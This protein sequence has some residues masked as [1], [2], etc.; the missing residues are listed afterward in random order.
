MAEFKLDRF[1]YNWK[2]EW[3]ENTPYLKDDIV[4]Y[5]GKTYACV[6]SHT[7]DADFFTTYGVTP[8]VS[9]ITV[10]NDT[11]LVDGLVQPT[12]D[13]RIGEIYKFDLSDPSLAATTF[14]FS[15]RADGPVNDGVEFTTGVTVAGAPGLTDSHLKISIQENTPNLFYYNSVT[16][17]YGNAATIT[18]SFWRLI[19]DGTSWKKNWTASTYYTTG[20][21][22]KF[23][24]YI[25][26]CTRTHTSV[27]IT[28]LGPI[29]DIEK[30]K[31][32]ATTYNWLNLWT[33]N[34][35]Y[36]LG[37]VIKYNGIVYI[38]TQKHRS[39]NSISDGLEFDQGKWAIVSKSDDWKTDWQPDI[40]Y[41]PDDVVR[42]GA[43]SYR[44][45]AGHTSSE[46]IDGG[47]ENDLANWEVVVS[48]IEYK[49]DWQADNR[50]KLNDIVKW[51]YSLWIC[52]TPHTSQSSLRTDES[53]WAVWLPGLGYEELWSV[54]IEYRKGDIVLY[55]G[56]SYTALQNSFNSP[57]SVNGILQDTGEWELLKQGYKHRGEWNDS[58]QFKTGD[59]VRNDGILY[60]A[61]AD[62]VSEFPDLENSWQILVTGNYWKQ[63]WNDNTVYYI[64]DV[65]TYASTAYVCILRHTST[66]SESRPDLDIL[67]PDQNYWTLLIQ[68]TET[69][70]LTTRGDI[71]IHD[72]I[73]TTRLAIGESGELLKVQDTEVPFWQN[74]EE[75]ADVYYVSASTG[76]DNPNYGSTL[77]APY[78]T[79]RYACQQVASNTPLAGIN[80]F[81]YDIS[82]AFDEYVLSRAL[83]IMAAGNALT[84]AASFESFLRS[85]N[86]RSGDPYFDITANGGI[87]PVTN[88]A[89]AAFNYF[90]G[91]SENDTEENLRIRDIINYLYVNAGT[92][93]TAV[94]LSSNNVQMPV[95]F[96]QRNATI[97][98]KTGIYSETLPISIPRNTTLVG[99]ELRSTTVQPAAGFETSNM[100]YVNNGSGIRNMTLTGLSGQLS[101]SSNSF[102]TRRPTA[103]A[104]VSLD[105]GQGASD[106]SVWITNKSPYIQNVT[107][108]GTGCIGLKVDGALHNGGNKSATA[109]DFTQILSDGIGYWVAN[110]GRSE[111]VSVFTYYN[112][113]GYLATEGGK[114]RAT[115]G[116]NSYGTYGVAAEGVNPAETPITGQM[117]NRSQ[118]ALIHTVNTDGSNIL[119]LGYTNAG[120]NYTTA[121][122]NV[123]GSNNNFDGR[124]SEF[125]DEA[126]Y[127][128]R[129]IDPADS[130]TPGGLN[131]QYLLNNAQ[132]GNTV[133]I[134][135][136]A[137]DSFGTS[138]AYTGMRLFIESGA[139]AGQYGYITSYDPTSKLATISREVDDAAGWEHIYPGYPIAAELD[140]TTRYSIEPRSIVEQPTF[141]NT[142]VSIGVDV[143]SMAFGAGKWV[144]IENSSQTTNYSVNGNTWSTGSLG[145]AGAW[146]NIVFANNV[147][148]VTSQADTTALL[149]SVNGLTWTGRTFNSAGVNYKAAYGNNIWIAV[150][151][152]STSGSNTQISVNDGIVWTDG[153]AVPFGARALD[154][155]Y[156]NGKFVIVEPS[157]TNAA[158]T[159]DGNSWNSIA[160]PLN[161]AWT[162]IKYGNGR[163]VLIGTGGDTLYSFDAITWYT[164]V[165][166]DQS[167][168][169]LGYGQGLFLAISSTSPAVA[170]SRDGQTWSII[171]NDSTVKE[172]NSTDNWTN[173]VFGN[174]NN[175]GAWMFTQLDS[176]DAEKVLTGAQAFVRTK[177]GTSR[178]Q[179]FVVY[180]P[181]SGYKTTPSFSIIDPNATIGALCDL[182]I[183]N[184]VLSQPE[185]RNRGSGYTRAV[186]TVAGDGFSDNYQI[187]NI[188]V[189]K[190]LTRRPDAG[191][192]LDILGI[193]ST[194]F[195]ITK[196][197]SITG[198]QPN[199]TASIR[200][201]PRIS[202]QESPNHEAGVIIRQE[203]SQ[204]RITGH[205]F[206][207]IGTGN[208]NSTKYPE[209]YLEGTESDNERQPFNEV[210]EA[211]GGRVFYTST[212]QEGNFR[213]GELFTVEQSTGIVS[214]NADFFDLGGLD[215]LSLGG[216]QVGGSAVVIREFSKESTFTANS[217]NIVPTQAAIIKFLE[218]RISG[219]GA[220]AITNVLVAAQVRINQN[221]IST[222]S[223]LPIT[224][225]QKMYLVKG[226]DGHYLASMIYGAS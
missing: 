5:R 226:A 70:V 54:G 91:A 200:I 115:N 177:V 217:N 48:G 197:E 109:N 181:G 170:H 167:W 212:D 11:F 173:I 33:I 146:N 46:Y 138:E 96:Q 131:Y 196:V 140:S 134:L 180:D 111:L 40:R 108:F 185:I 58:T 12:L 74:F 85:T 8:R 7:S 36:D 220:N 88:D 154:I 128:A 184:G 216:I 15:N 159:T 23:K 17:G 75:I 21:I 10:E 215:E 126:I 147:F 218:S 157:S 191:D 172:L 29:N 105:P 101:T 161:R 25:Y 27:V 89:T 3:V 107:T 119:A 145:A 213:V 186:G 168:T 102:G 67:Q 144:A 202:N 34:T 52:V 41:R 160:L 61:T 63:E 43:I 222:T 72:D 198:T 51:R 110:G 124:Y 116:N 47:F 121:T 208:F 162:A 68:G 193:D 163:F 176:R 113:I 73:S 141:V 211:G 210:F 16:P 125:R 122:L 132:G 175:A 83:T 171:N 188:I 9:K 129:L 190:N 199:I 78:R 32:V 123:E 149:T 19:H 20:D 86:P 201:S 223:G 76:T 65:V 66:A 56:Y 142:S 158:Y 79:I 104:F 120:Q 22:V 178:I 143:R 50:Y 205:D 179:E 13:L 165:I 192:N 135:L 84:N 195:R 97:F 156:G 194:T 69:N 4:Y 187:G 24:G 219:G 182:R 81:G 57:P 127:Q 133:S 26:Q 35:N 203:Y 64:G 225:K 93:S 152:G 95:A 169:A 118:E 14:K 39:R 53:K 60:I 166:P 80:T 221:N 224:V 87:N 45:I 42:H 2:N 82:G 1:R 44:C 18:E 49:F 206:L 103:G 62:S 99:D 71:R 90:S 94:V 139:G 30:W 77:G 137:A 112:Y 37:D 6:K 38:C 117:N 114:I 148:V 155:V 28:A 92:F 189:V 150:E 31:I 183:G 164:G 100:F 55:G 136:A 214:I 204:L 130:T 98:V 174:P 59:V 207:D 151:T 106:A 153:A 209:L